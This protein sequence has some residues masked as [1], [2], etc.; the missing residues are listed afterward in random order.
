MEQ[1]PY[2]AFV[3]PVPSYYPD[4]PMLNPNGARNELLRR[5]PMGLPYTVLL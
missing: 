4:A 1:C 5:N 2:V 3:E